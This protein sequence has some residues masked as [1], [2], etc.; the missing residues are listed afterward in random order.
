[1]SEPRPRRRDDRPDEV[2]R[3]RLHPPTA[4]HVVVLLTE[5][6]A[7]HDIYP[8]EYLGGV[9]YAL[10][11]TVTPDGRVIRPVPEPGPPAVTGRHRQV[12]DNAG[13]R[14]SVGHRDGVVSTLAW[15]AGATPVPP[16][17]VVMTIP[18]ATADPT[19]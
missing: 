5:A 4:A 6:R 17:H 7:Q 2:T 12:D 14:R 3:Q 18:P 11:R 16:V 19:W 13:A 15:I 1:M 9:L 8:S 10:T